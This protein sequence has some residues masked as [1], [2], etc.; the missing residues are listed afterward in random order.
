MDK[1]SGRQTTQRLALSLLPAWAAL[2][3]DTDD[4]P[5]G[6]P[7]SQRRPGT[8]AA[9]RKGGQPSVELVEQQ[10]DGAMLGEV[11]TAEFPTLITASPMRLLASGW[12]SR[13]PGLHGVCGQAMSAATSIRPIR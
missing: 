4:H 8:T 6:L 10:Q 1:A 11:T 5:A 2:R 9:D 3:A 13:P 7:Y 12:R